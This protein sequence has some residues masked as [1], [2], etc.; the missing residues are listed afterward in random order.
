MPPLVLGLN[1]RNPI[2]VTQDTTSLMFPRESRSS[3][4]KREDQRQTAFRS[5]W[6]PVLVSPTTRVILNDPSLYITGKVGDYYAF[7]SR[8]ICLAL[9]VMVNTALL[10]HTLISL[11]TTWLPLFPGHWYS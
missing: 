4:T 1:E 11:Q 6:F 7:Q 10:F 5:C 8:P 9:E 2:V 3:V